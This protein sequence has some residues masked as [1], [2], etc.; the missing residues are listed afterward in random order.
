MLAFRFHVVTVPLLY[1]LRGTEMMCNFFL[2]ATAWVEDTPA[3]D[4]G[5]VARRGHGKP[6][7]TDIKLWLECFARMATILITRFPEKGPSCGRTKQQSSGPPKTTRGRPGWPMTGS[8]TET[9]CHGNISIGQHRM[10]AFITRRS[11]GGPT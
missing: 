2:A 11:R 8:T 6:P 10:L 7:D 3:P 1:C 5:Q 4:G 9:C